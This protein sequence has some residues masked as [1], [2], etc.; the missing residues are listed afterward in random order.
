M[1]KSKI[2]NHNLVLIVEFIQLLSNTLHANVQKV[3]LEIN[4]KLK[5]IKLM[6]KQ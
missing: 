4:V 3:S 5:H 2:K 1:V 6:K